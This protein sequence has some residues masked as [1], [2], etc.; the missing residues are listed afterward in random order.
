MNGGVLD[1][2]NALWR[3]LTLAI[4]LEVLYQSYRSGGGRHGRRVWL[5]KHGRPW[6]VA[7]GYMV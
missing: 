2:F 7:N 4:Y 3:R 6:A 5:R 1:P